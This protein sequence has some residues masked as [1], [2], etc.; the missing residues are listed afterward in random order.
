MRI[1]IVD[2]SK[3]MRMIVRRQLG[4]TDLPDLDLDEAENG[5]QALE[6]VRS[7]DYDLVFSDWNMPE[8]NGMELLRSLRAEGNTIKFGFVTSEAQPQM[9]DQALEAGAQFLIVKPFTAEAFQ[10][11]LARVL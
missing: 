9:K 8:M 1:L 2:D 4:Q 5:Q 10:E 3:A 7:G 6:K 11:I